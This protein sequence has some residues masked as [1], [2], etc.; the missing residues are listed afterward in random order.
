[1]WCR[2]FWLLL[3]CAVPA[4][5]KQSKPAPPG[6]MID[7]GGRRLHLNCAGAGS[8]AVVVENGGGAFSVQWE[9]VRRIVAKHARFCTYDRAG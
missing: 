9:L 5:R 7:L 3:V 2:A 6:Q 4:A 1:V 8:P